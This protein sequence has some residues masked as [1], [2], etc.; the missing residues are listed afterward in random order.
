MTFHHT[1]VSMRSLYENSFDISFRVIIVTGG[2]L[3]TGF[4][5]KYKVPSLFIVSRLST[6]N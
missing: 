3:L 6:E 1:A 2:G 4:D 5:S